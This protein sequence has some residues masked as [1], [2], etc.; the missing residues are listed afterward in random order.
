MSA[1]MDKYLSRRVLVADDDQAMRTLFVKSLKSLGVEET[2]E[3]ADGN[4][5]MELFN[6]HEFSLVLLDWGMP[7]MTGLEILRVIRDMP[8]DVPVIMVTAE[9][10]RERVL[11]AAEAGVTD[12]LIKP[13]LPDVL[14]DKLL[15]HCRP[16]VNASIYRCRNLMNSNVVSVG[17]DA[18]VEEAIA[19]FLEHGISGLPVV[20]EFNRLLGN[21]TEYD[22]LRSVTDPDL[23][24]ESVSSVMCTAVLTVDE[25]TIPLKVVRIMQEHRVRRVPVVRGD[26]LVGVISRRDLLR[27]VSENDEVLR[28][29]LEQVRSLTAGCSGRFGQSGQSPPGR[30]THAPCRP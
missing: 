20:G 28:A 19:L 25:D 14:R 12:Y 30:Q 13:I 6:Q 3:A 9:N 24:S 26:E 15:R 8:S 18:T 17:P 22:L 29:F 5:A 1:P 2:L 11:E 4:E 27:Y 23:K 7:G 16:K 21:V 10:R